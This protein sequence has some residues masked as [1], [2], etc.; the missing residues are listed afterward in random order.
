MSEHKESIDIDVP[1]SRAWDQWTQFEEF[2]KFMDGVRQVQQMG[3]KHLHRVAEIAGKQGEWDVEITEPYHD[4][5]VA[6]RS[7]NGKGKPRVVRSHR[8]D[9]KEI[10][11]LLELDFEPD[12]M[13]EAI[14]DKIG[15]VSGRIKG[16]LELFKEFIEQRGTESG[17]GTGV[18]TTYKESNH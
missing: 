12:G 3:E 14:G 4:E 7:T 8:L 2:P 6:W 1:V 15:F 9:E 16:N 13:I 11:V 18:V 17:A 10:R 5:R